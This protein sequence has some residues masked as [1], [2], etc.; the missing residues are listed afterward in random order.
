[1]NDIWVVKNG[2]EGMPWTMDSTLNAEMLANSLHL[3][4]PLEQITSQPLQHLLKM[5]KN[6]EFLKL[7]ILPRTNFR[8]TP[9]RT[10]NDFDI[11]RIDSWYETRLIDRTSR[12]R[13]SGLS[14]RF[15]S[16]A[17]A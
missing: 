3:Y 4:L 5:N 9:W 1:M 13:F 8:G 14:S 10:R 16:I 11:D 15:Q 2:N 17:P 6:A 7:D 12:I